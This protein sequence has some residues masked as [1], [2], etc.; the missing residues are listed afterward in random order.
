MTSADA[1]SGRYK[2]YICDSLI[3][4]GKGSCDT[5][6][7]NAERFERLIIDQ[8]RR[9]VLTENNIRRAGKGGY[10]LHHTYAVRQSLER[11]GQR[12]DRVRTSIYG[13]RILWWS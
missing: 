6:R 2:Y 4:H 7:L 12:R 3:K 9:N 5:P 1:H 10:P 8:I 11:F 13:Y